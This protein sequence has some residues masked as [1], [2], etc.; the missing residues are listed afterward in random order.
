M[1]IN[2]NIEELEPEKLIHRPKKLRPK[3]RHNREVWK[4]IAKGVCCVAV[5]GIVVGVAYY[6]Q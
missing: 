6:L 4:A 1:N 5:V 3:N 2:N